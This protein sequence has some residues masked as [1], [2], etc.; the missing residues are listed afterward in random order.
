M[1][2]PTL[3]SAMMTASVTGAGLVIAF[4]ALIAR[5]SDSIFSCRFEL[6]EKKNLEVE[7]IRSNPSSFKDETLEETSSRLKE[8]SK[9]I[10]SIK[11]FPRYL[12]I[13]VGVSF[14]L[15]LTNA[16][17]CVNWLR[18]YSE[19]YNPTQNDWILVVLFI[20]AIGLFGIVGGLGLADVRETM[21]IQF[22]N[23]AKKKTEIKEGIM[24]APREAETIAYIKSRLTNFKIDFESNVL[25]KVSGNLLR[26][27]IMIPSGRNPEYLIEVMAKPN[28]DMIYRRSTGYEPFKEE[29][30]VKTILITDFMGHAPRIDVA[31]AYWD[32]VIDIGDKDDM[33][34]K[35]KKILTE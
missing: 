29:T 3:V 7:Q 14:G 8:L 15:F 26:P 6:L 35:L 32:F 28:L 5:M 13:G 17:F 31:K 2:S 21:K 24:H 30:G 10:D 27:D 19:P 11:T 22:K 4:Y 12:A 33:A 18:L 9:E 16:L 1:L 23:L 34:E 20:F 25:I